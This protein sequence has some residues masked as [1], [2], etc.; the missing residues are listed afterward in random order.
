IS[1]I[2]IH[3][4]S[5]RRL[6]LDMKNKYNATFRKFRLSHHIFAPLALLDSLSLSLSSLLRIFP[7]GLFGMTSMNSTPPFSH[8]YLALWSSTCFAMPRATSSSEPVAA[9]DLTTKALGTSPAI[10]SGTWMTV[11]SETW[12]WV[13]RWAS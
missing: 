8:L 7:L 10:S 12:G 3:I 6:P 13:R 5:F 2:Y 4:Y 1:H 11:Q 9:A